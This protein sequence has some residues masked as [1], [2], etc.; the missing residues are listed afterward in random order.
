MPSDASA[1]STRERT[2]LVLSV[3]HER[4]PRG[5]ALLGVLL[6]DGWLQRYVLRRCGLGQLLGTCIAAQGI[7]NVI[8]P[9]LVE[10]RHFPFM[11]ASVRTSMTADVG[12]PSDE[13]KDT[14]VGCCTL[15]IDLV[16]SCQHQLLPR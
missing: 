16:P 1:L 11:L 10:R 15:S 2:A 9:P 4:T 14:L 7:A 13:A 6:L 3:G 8:Q 5:S 12:T